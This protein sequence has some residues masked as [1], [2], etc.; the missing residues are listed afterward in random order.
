[1]EEVDQHDPRTLEVEYG[2][3][4]ISN[5]GCDQGERFGSKVPRG[6]DSGSD[7]DGNNLLQAVG[8]AR[9]DETS[10]PRSLAEP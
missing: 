7:L 6:F 10:S 5:W 9:A 2:R 4:G 3:S 1:V 8:F